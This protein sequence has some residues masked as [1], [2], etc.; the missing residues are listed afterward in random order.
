MTLRLKT[1]L[2]ELQTGEFLSSALSTSSGANGIVEQKDT[3]LRLRLGNAR[4][5]SEE[6][7]PGHTLNGAGDA[8][9]VLHQRGIERH[10]YWYLYGGTSTLICEGRRR[11]SRRTSWIEGSDSWRGA[12]VIAGDGMNRPFRFLR[13]RAGVI[14]LTGRL[15]CR[16]ALSASGVVR[17]EAIVRSGR[18][19]LFARPCSSGPCGL[20]RVDTA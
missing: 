11:S 15:V 12:T 8:A 5:T 19:S 2:Q 6:R 10:C 4:W 9:R 18:R 7:W 13:W 20:R 3:R 17:V 1:I 14:S 16:T